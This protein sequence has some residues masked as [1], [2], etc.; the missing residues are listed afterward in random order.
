[1]DTKQGTVQTFNYAGGAHLANQNQN[2]CVR[3]E[4]GKC[5]A[6][7]HANA[8]TDVQ[9][10][11]MAATANT[12]ACCNYITDGTDKFGFDCIEIPG[13]TKSNGGKRVP[14]K[15]CG[16]DAG[17]AT[18][19]ATVEK[20]VCNSRAPFNVRFR[21]DSCESDGAMG[22]GKKPTQDGFKLQYKLV[23]C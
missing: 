14:S 11:G 17:L 18:A 4:A 2:I 7:W 12:K 20:T 1:L 23:A 22:D 10:N 13:A 5:K 21:S 6:C 3:Q 16:H 19:D 9:V 15:V 8:A